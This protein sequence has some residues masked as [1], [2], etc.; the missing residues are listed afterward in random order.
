MSTRLTR[1]NYNLLHPLA[2][3]IALGLSN[4]TLALPIELSF[5]TPQ[6]AQHNRCRIYDFRRLLRSAVAA[7]TKSGNAQDMSIYDP[8]LS[9]LESL[10]SPR[11]DYNPAG[12]SQPTKLILRSRGTSPSEL[13]A[14]D[15][16]AA[17]STVVDKESE[18]S[19]QSPADLTSLFEVTPEFDEIERIIGSVGYRFRVPHGDNSSDKMLLMKAKLPNSGII[20]LDN[21]LTGQDE[22]DY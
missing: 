19:L 11:I 10:E 14:L 8:L 9:A 15:Q 2:Y 6:Q 20:I 4:G 21:W 5:P 12:K 16:L 7:S 3:K 22:P 13:S 17:L 18:A 1:E